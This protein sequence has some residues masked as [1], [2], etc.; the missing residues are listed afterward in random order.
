MFSAETTS[1]RIERSMYLSP[2]LRDFAD[3]FDV[4]SRKPG[5]FFD[6]DGLHEA[7]RRL[8]AAASYSDEASAWTYLLMRRVS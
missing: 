5:R 1:R 6:I 3:A 7:V 4:I 2:G 8:G